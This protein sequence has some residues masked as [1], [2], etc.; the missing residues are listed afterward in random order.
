[1][2]R[3]TARSLTSCG[4]YPE[5]LLAFTSISSIEDKPDQ[6]T[7]HLVKARMA[8]MASTMKNEASGS[9]DG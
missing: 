5:F 3:R 7:S 9:F 8:S 1:M 2:E 4:T 6:E